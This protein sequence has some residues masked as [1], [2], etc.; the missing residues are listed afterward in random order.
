[1]ADGVF[2][3]QDINKI[4]GV[5]IV[6]CHL[7]LVHCDDIE[8][9]RILSSINLTP[10]GRIFCQFSAFTDPDI[11]AA[12]ARPDTLATLDLGNKHWFRTPE[13]SA[14]II[15]DAGLSVRRV[16]DFVPGQYQGWYGQYWQFYELYR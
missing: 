3:T 13:Q 10:G 8:C 1:L 11:G 7:V 4:P 9:K 16:K 12:E 6:I 5:D 2:L 15:K 14:A